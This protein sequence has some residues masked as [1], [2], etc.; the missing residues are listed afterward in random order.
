MTIR[1]PSKHEYGTVCAVC[2]GPHVPAHVARLTRWREP[3]ACLFR[4]DHDKVTWCACGYCAYQDE[5]AL[6]LKC[7]MCGWERPDRARLFNLV[8][9][10]DVTG[11]S[12]T[13]IVAE[14]VQFSDGTTVLRW[15]KA[16]TARPDKVKPTTVIHESVESV[17]ALH[18]HN[19]ATRIVWLP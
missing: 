15:L 1:C 8:R 9:E 11:I 13:G 19:G 6:V 5:H 3:E 17:E 12:G 14:G 2:A 18:G 4:S 7:A 16:G 10:Q